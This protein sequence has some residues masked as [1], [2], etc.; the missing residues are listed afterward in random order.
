MPQVAV[1]RSGAAARSMDYPYRI[2]RHFWTSGAGF[3][4]GTGHMHEPRVWSWILGRFFEP[5]FFAQKCLV[6]NLYGMVNM[7]QHG[8]IAAGRKLSFH[9]VSPAL[10]EDSLV[11]FGKVWTAS[12]DNSHELCAKNSGFANPGTPR[13]DIRG[14]DD[15]YM[16]VWIQRF[17]HSIARCAGRIAVWIIFWKDEFV[18]RAFEPTDEPRIGLTNAK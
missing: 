2:S 5:Q 18:E 4:F 7:N 13:I 17:D 8:E 10:C 9:P 15:K 6:S 16:T 11:Y 12:N 1:L 14:P 3:W